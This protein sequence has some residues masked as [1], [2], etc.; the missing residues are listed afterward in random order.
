MTIA[1]WQAVG[2]GSETSA[3]WPTHATGDLGYLVVQS[4]SGGGLSTPSGWALIDGFPMSAG[5]ELLYLFTKTAASGA[6]GAASLSGGTN[7]TWGVIFTVRNPHTTLPHY[8]ILQA[9][10]VGATTSGAA[11][12]FS[13]GIDDVLVINIFAW[14][15]DSAGPLSSGETNATLSGVTE[16]YDAGTATNNGGG[17]AI[18]SGTIAA[19][20]RVDMTTV[21]FGSST[22]YGAVTLAIAPVADETIAGTVTINGAAAANGETVRVLDL[23]QPAASYLVVNGTTGGGTGAFSMLAPYT[24]H[25]YQVVYEDGASYG[26]SAVDQAV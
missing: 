4:G 18:I 10:A 21:T 1:N 13:C 24:D 12:G 7:H 25:D 14:S 11:P 5:G 20:G 8:Q 22:A 15:A 9:N 3:A 23:T 19:A 2:T 16:R 17:I 26:A 6:E